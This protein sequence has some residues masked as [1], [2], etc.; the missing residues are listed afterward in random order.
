VMALLLVLVAYLVGSFPTSY[1][2]GHAVRGIDL[3]EHGSGN[4]GATNAFRVLGW[5]AAVPILIVDI[6]KGFF[7]TYLF[8]LFDGRASLAWMMAYGAAAIIGHMFSVYVG[9]RGGKGVATGAGVFL[10]LAPVAVLVAAGIWAVIV[11]ATGYV[12]LASVAAAAA[13][14]LLVAVSGRRLPILVLALVLGAFVIYAHRANIQRL[15][16]GEEHRFGGR[17]TSSPTDPDSSAPVDP[18]SPEPAPREP[19]DPAASGVP[20]TDAMRPGE[21]PVGEQ[22]G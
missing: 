2:M 17:G 22:S 4:L 7:P 8:P 18:A 5:R 11:L 3:R 1:L 13:L 15:L 20:G 12:S 16:R 21:P 6:A 10:A 19:P 9:F 14:P